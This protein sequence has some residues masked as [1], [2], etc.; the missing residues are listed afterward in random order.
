MSLA[1]KIKKRSQI[2]L[3]L[4][5]KMLK[6]T[7]PLKDTSWPPWCIK[8]GGKVVFYLMRINNVANNKANAI[9]FDCCEVMLCSVEGKPNIAMNRFGSFG[10]N[11]EVQIL[12]NEIHDQ[13]I[14]GH[15]GKVA[16]VKTEMLSQLWEAV[17]YTSIY[18][19]HHLS[20]AVHKVLVSL[21]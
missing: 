9:A 10:S 12:F 2:N 5:I 4:G 7:S 18:L 8:E 14:W 17:T 13:S 19:H 3:V 20:L 11:I 15:L 21:L 1:V 16:L 6:K